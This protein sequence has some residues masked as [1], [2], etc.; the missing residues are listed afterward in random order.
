LLEKFKAIQMIDA[1]LVGVIVPII[2]A[3][4]I[5]MMAAPPRSPLFVA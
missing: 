1:Y 4:V 2:L 3:C 5:T